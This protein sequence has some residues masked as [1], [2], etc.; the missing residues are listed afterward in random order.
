MY[1]RISTSGE[2]I[3]WNRDG[4]TMGMHARKIGE[5]LAVV[6]GLFVFGCS[7]TLEVP[8]PQ[9]P[10]GACIVTHNRGGNKLRERLSIVGEANADQWL[11]LY[12][13]RIGEEFKKPFPLDK[14][15]VTTLDCAQQTGFMNGAD[16]P[17]WIPQ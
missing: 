8:S 15:A 7:T 1:L 5:G 17:I 16:V 13:D 9:R 14:G 10:R 3:R 2:K 6:A 4:R 11:V 12:L